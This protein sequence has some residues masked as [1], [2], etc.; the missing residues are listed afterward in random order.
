M[1][2]HV[3]LACTVSMCCTNCIV[4][5]CILGEENYT[6]WGLLGMGG[7]ERGGGGI[8]RMQHPVCTCCSGESRP[9]VGGRGGVPTGV[10][11]DSRIHCNFSWPPGFCFILSCVE[12]ILS[13]LASCA[14]CL[15]AVCCLDSPFGR[16]LWWSRTGGRRGCVAVEWDLVAM[17]C[18]FCDGWCLVWSLAP[19]VAGWCGM[20]GQRCRERLNDLFCGFQ[21]LSSCRHGLRDHVEE[22]GKDCSKQRCF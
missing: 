16:L 13:W 12:G 6:I 21:S 18:S 10:Y 22:L 1:S 8:E 5:F 4:P 2:W 15:I 7:G 14:P 11:V 3:F 9:G 17:L 19:G 20:V